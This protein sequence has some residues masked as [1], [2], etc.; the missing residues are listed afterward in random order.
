MFLAGRQQPLEQAFG[1]RHEQS[2]PQVVQKCDDTLL[3]GITS[4][5]EAGAF[6]FVEGGDGGG[7]RREVGHC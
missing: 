5:P 2:L 1:L 7:E 3:H 4:I 6:A